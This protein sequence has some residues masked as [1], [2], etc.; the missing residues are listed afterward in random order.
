MSVE[1]NY[2][3]LGLFIA[4]ALMVILG[5]AV[6]FIQ[7][8]RT[9]DAIPFVTYTT[10]NV[11]G[12]DVSSPVRYLGVSVGRVTGIRVDPRAGT[13]EIDFEVFTDRL[14]QLGVNVGQVRER[15]IN[16]G[17][18]FP[19]LRTQLMGNPVT[20]EAYLVIEKPK[21]PPP[22]I[23]LGFKPN[24]PYI[25]SLPSMVTTVQER[26][27]ALLERAEGTLQTLR[28]IIAKLPA[29]L[30]RSDRFFTN[31]ERIMKE[32]QLPAFSADSRQFFTTT[33][34]QIDRMTSELDGLIGKEGTLVKFTEETQATLKAADLP[35]TT[36]A[37][38]EAASDSR[39]A[40]ADLR[41]SLPA[42]RDSLDQLRE[43][44]R[45][46]EEQPESVV[47]GPRPAGAKHP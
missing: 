16:I 5:T 32:S 11:T 7:R 9:R 45:L 39:L 21:V 29:S 38:R 15:I 19:N 20:G 43:L 17:G 36:K 37:T 44:T 27:P 33:S 6:L 34:A 30:D 28:E 25:P 23:E 4:I 35:A 46:L 42:I 24:R 1:K 12:L 14:T 2:A 8:L 47:Y 18:V 41:R 26:L 40:A 22:A 10:E 3:R 31:V 13:V